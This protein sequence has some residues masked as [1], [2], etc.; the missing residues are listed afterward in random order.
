[1]AK[2]QRIIDS[3]SRYSG[4]PPTTVAGDRGERMEF[5]PRDLPDVQAFEA[6]EDS[7]EPYVIVEG[8]RIDL[9]A[10]EFLGDSRLWPYIA[11]INPEV[12]PLILV[13]GTTLMVPRMFPR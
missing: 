12:D 11:D 3:V 13:P 1:M 6:M 10:A 9:L 5:P 8:D 4:L 7:A 2:L